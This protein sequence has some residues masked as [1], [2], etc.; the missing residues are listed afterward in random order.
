[1]LALF[2]A[3]AHHAPAAGNAELT[4]VAGGVFRGQAAPAHRLPEPQPAVVRHDP[5]PRQ[6]R[7]GAK[8]DG[9]EDYEACRK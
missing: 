2:L 7:T 8:Q 5:A 4:L 3:R 9:D 6:R 1:V